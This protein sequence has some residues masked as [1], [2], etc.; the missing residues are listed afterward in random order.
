MQSLKVAS[1]T[2][3]EENIRSWILY[4]LRHVLET[5]KVRNAVLK[6][7][8]S[9]QFKRVGYTP[10]YGKTLNNRKNSSDLTAYLDKIIKQYPPDRS[11]K[12]IVLFTISNILCLS[13]LIS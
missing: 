9:E 1:E 3:K 8:L 7:T 12:Y 5:E 2:T 11:S 13:L 10:I 6:A 4:A